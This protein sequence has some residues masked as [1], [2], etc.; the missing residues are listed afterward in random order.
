MQRQFQVTFIAL[1]WLSHGSLAAQE[2][3]APAATAAMQEIQAGRFDAAKKTLQQGL[4][5]TP[6]AAELWNLLGISETELHEP[7]AAA[8]AFQTGLQLAPGSTSLNENTGFLF[9][10]E[11]NYSA[12]K[13]YLRRALEL[14]S[15]KP[16]V[17]FSLAA[18]ELRT[19]EQAKALAELQ[20]LEPALSGTADYWVER[21]HAE[22]AENDPRAEYSF[23]RALD[24]DSRNLEALNGAASA[25]EKQGLDEKALSY[26]IKARESHPN[27]V[28]TLLH[29]GT[30]CLRRDLGMDALDAA[31]KAYALQPANNYAVF[32]LARANIS[33]QQ[34]PEA[35]DLFEQLA[36]RM[37]RYAPAYYAMGWL[38]RKLDRNDEARRQ[39]RRAL[40]IDPGLF[41][42]RAELAQIYLDNGELEIAEQSFAKV[43]QQDPKNAKANS[44]MGALML[45][46]GKLV[47]AQR[48]LE[49]AI[50]SDPKDGAAHY[51][52]SQVLLREHNTKRAAEERSLGLALNAEATRTSKAPLRLAMPDGSL[53]GSGYGG[54]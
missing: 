12:A 37:P 34:W 36:K 1:C 3:S 50:A 10:R 54:R 33:Q 2:T 15:Q 40:A 8:K 6:K 25:A 47:Q 28:P 49:A 43:L 30:V 41:D 35:Y 42:A 32:L 27:D 13:R 24:L 29:F 23:E 51:K 44:G 4:R 52:L 26:L 17:R 45:R 38:D 11:G 14:G 48:Y 22:L 21:G 39:L 18:A 16:G 31:K 20:Q 46:R 5:S 7:K 53:P 9:F 19:G